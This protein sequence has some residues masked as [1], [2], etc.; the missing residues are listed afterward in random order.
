MPGVLLEAVS[1]GVKLSAEDRIG[2][3]ETQLKGFC[4]QAGFSPFCFLTWLR[5]TQRYDSSHWLGAVLSL[6][7]APVFP[8]FSSCPHTCQ[9]G[10]SW[11][12]PPSF[13]KQPTK[14]RGVA[15]ELVPHL[16]F[17][18][19]FY[20]VCSMIMKVTRHIHCQL[21]KKNDT[22]CFTVEK[23]PMEAAPSC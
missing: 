14:A 4:H 1:T 23:S 13:L 17:C 9:G 21:L 11:S 22:G 10:A 6:P 7:S 12:C 15:W 8:G 3:E 19:S 18:C 2:G 5:G 20:A 16:R